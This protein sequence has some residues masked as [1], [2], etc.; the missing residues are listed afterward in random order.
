MLEA[1]LE[2]VSR[3]RARFAIID[4]TGAKTIDTQAA[5][6]LTGAARALR[7]LGVTPVLTGI[8]AEVAQTLVGLGVDLRDVMTLGTL[9]SGIAYATQRMAQ[10]G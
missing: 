3:T 7:L 5:G 6:A 9:Q 1:L 4:I 8:R 2:G 10:S